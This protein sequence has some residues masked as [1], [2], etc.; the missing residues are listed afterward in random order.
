[1]GL[2]GFKGLVLERGLPVATI[3]GVKSKAT[4][5]SDG[6]NPA[7]LGVQGLGLRVYETLNPKPLNLGEHAANFSIWY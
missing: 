5:I 6:R 7:C 3:G 1:M 2:Y 4:A